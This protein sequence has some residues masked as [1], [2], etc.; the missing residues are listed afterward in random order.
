M[1]IETAVAFFSGDD[2]LFKFTVRDSDNPPALKDL[3][4]VAEIYFA[5]AKSAGKPAFITKTLTANPSEVTVTNA[6]GGEFTVKVPRAE[7]EPLSSKYTYY[8][9]KVTDS[10]DNAHTTS[11]GTTIIS[12]NTIVAP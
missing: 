4:G 5:I 1:S 3:T 11:Y 10:A 9:V 2:V 6:L 7:T 12:A 8:E